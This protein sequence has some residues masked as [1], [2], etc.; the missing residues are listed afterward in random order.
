MHTFNPSTQGAEVKASL[1]YILR[2]CPAKNKRQKAKTKDK[3]KE[4]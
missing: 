3:Q 2:S 1:I 4:P